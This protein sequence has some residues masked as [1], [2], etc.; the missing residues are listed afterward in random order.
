M[1]ASEEPLGRG[2]VLVVEFTLGFKTKGNVVDKS[3]SKADSCSS[4]RFSTASRSAPDTSL[5]SNRRQRQISFRSH[6]ILLNLS[7][8]EVIADVVHFG[9]RA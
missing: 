3:R 6:L 4:R 9:I 5:L 8:I 2:V 1:D 7:S